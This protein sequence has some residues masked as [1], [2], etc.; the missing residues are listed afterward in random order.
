MLAFLG[1]SSQ[2]AVR[3]LG[4]IECLKLHLEDPAHNN[5]ECSSL[6][7]CSGGCGCGVWV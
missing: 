6:D 3:G 7:V 1:F 4:P 2:A 5:S